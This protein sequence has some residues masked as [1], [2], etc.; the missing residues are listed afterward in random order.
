MYQHESI[1][2]AG[3]TERRF[4]LTMAT[5]ETRNQTPSTP[6]DLL[7]PLAGWE[8]AA[9]WNRATFDWMTK[10]WQQWLA[11]AT[12]LPPHWIETLA[13]S[14]RPDAEHAVAHGEPK[15]PARARAA[16]KTKSNKAP[17]A[18]ARG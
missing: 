4:F 17:K 10:G 18:R 5:M 6:L 16:A 1:A 14:P 13:P 7:S 8:A 15:R 12:T 11:L 2:Y 9:R 3:P